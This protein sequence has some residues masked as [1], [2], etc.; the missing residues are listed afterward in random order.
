LSKPVELLARH[1]GRFH[2]INPI[3]SQRFATQPPLGT[4][5]VDFMGCDKVHIVAMT[6]SYF[7][8]DAEAVLSPQDEA[9]F[10]TVTYTYYEQLNGYCIHR[11]PGPFLAVQPTVDLAKRPSQQRINPLVEESPGSRSL[12]CPSHVWI[13]FQSRRKGKPRGRS[14]ASNSCAGSVRFG[15]FGLSRTRQRA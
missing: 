5:L 9:K 1:F 6:G 14:E 7:R 15:Q 2:A 8:G 11:A 13:G 10:D 3:R 4:H 12:H